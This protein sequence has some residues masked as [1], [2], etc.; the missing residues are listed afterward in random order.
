M[1]GTPVGELRLPSLDPRTWTS[2][3][4]AN[5]Y[6]L[7][8]RHREAGTVH[9]GEPAGPG[10]ATVRVF[11]HTEAAAVLSD[12]R[13]GRNARTAAEAAGAP[14]P[15]SPMPA[16]ARS[17]RA[18]VTNW[19]V[20]LDPPRHT[21][22]RALVQ[23]EFSPSAV[24]DLHATIAGIASDLLAPMVTAD[25]F[26][27]IE[28][29]AA[30][31]PMLVIGAQ[32]G[33]PRADQPWLRHHAMGLQEASSSR[34]AAN[35]GAHLVA[36]RS[37]TALTAYFRSMVRARRVDPAGDLVSMLVHTEVAGERLSRDEIVGM[38]VH[39][40]TAGH[41]TTTNSL[42]KAVLTLKSHPSLRAAVPSDGPAPGDLV[43]ELVRFDPPVQS[44]TRWA[45][46]QDRL[47]GVTIPAGSRVV[48]MLGAANRDPSRFPDPDQPRLD[49]PAGR[50]VGFGL[51]AHYCLGAALARAELRIGL[52][53]L[54]AAVPGDL[55]VESVTYPPDMVFH[56]PS[57]LLLRRAGAPR[58]LIPAGRPDDPMPH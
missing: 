22:M 20:F 17:L 24:A 21:R 16:D 5:P 34:A 57:Q 7:L 42:A 56:G 13:Y 11:G 35:P 15:P 43:D 45:Y 23:R 48:V 47:G 37:A 54:L 26:D 25:R 36:E 55:D 4:L 44:V 14:A 33:V 9:I 18:L 3:Q 40:I 53:A 19:L 28:S 41:E 6:P 31:L 12:P 29:F 52:G 38:C 46:A 51:G 10:P 32:L 58:Q 49:R 27:L 2:E 39:L 50:T 1:S 30:P 8:R